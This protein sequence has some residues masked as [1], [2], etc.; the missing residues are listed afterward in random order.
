MKVV[1]KTQFSLFCGF[2]QFGFSAY[3]LH[4]DSSLNETVGFPYSC[5]LCSTEITLGTLKLQHDAAYSFQL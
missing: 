1:I 5:F 2:G 3:L 4:L